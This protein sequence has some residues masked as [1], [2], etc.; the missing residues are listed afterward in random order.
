MGGLLTIAISA[1]PALAGLAGGPLGAALEAIT[2]GVAHKVFGTEDA[3]TIKQQMA[4]DENKA[5]MFKAELAAATEQ[6]RI[7]HE[8]NS[9]M[10]AKQVEDISGARAQF[11]ALTA[12]G[13]RMS[14]APIIVS[15]VIVFFFFG[16]TTLLFFVS[17]DFGDRVYQLLFM[18]FG[19]EI[20]MAAQVTNFWLGSSFGS[21]KKDD[22]IAVQSA[23]SAN[24]TPP[25]V[26]RN[27]T[28]IANSAIKAI[29]NGNGNGDHQP[30]D[31]AG[32]IPGG[33]G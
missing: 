31:R 20:T 16:G 15:V 8:E 14:V 18:A 17:S 24:A 13:S 2:K 26:L 32:G 28:A 22:T 11:A 9:D 27:M 30:V 12:A 7:M 3:E 6:L 21:Q 1:L 5:E 25:S 10:R 19:A 23:A 29:K 33:G 4:A